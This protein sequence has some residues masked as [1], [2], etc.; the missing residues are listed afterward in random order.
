MPD[1]APSAN[2]RTPADRDEDL[3]RFRRTLEGLVGYPAT[4]GNRVDILRNGDEIF[5]SMLEAIRGAEHTVDFMTFVYWTGEIAEEFA[6][7]LAERATS[8]VRVRVLLDAVGARLMDD[9]VTTSLTD[10]GANVE[11]FRPPTTWKV[12][13]ANHRTHRKILV[14]DEAIGFTGGVGIAEEWCGDARDE[15]E[16]RDT[17]VRLEGPA[18]DGLRSAF[19]SDWGE[20]GNPVCDER[21]RFPDQPAVG[22]SI[23]QVVKGSAGSGWS[24]IGTLFE[25]MIRTAT[26]RLRLTTAYFVPDDRY[27]A[28]LID[29]IDRGVEVEVLVPGPHADK[30]FVQVAGEA[31]YEPLLDAGVRISCFQPSMLHAKVL[32]ADSMVA[33]I[34]SSNF[35]HRSLS[36]DD[37]ANVVVFDPAVAAVLDRHFDED[38]ARS[39][40]LDPSR[41]RKRSMP[42]KALEK[43][44]TVIDD[45]L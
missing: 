7:A 26:K 32:T 10:A 9:G 39:E 19:T 8:G 5:P 24:D 12:W 36:L 28:A 14:C 3:H 1:A 18:V 37:E 25:S 34:G 33:T 23:V 30:R 13:E 27:A 2:E 4:E 35:N 21:D 38:L 29:A 6:A 41:W 42:Q 15:T 44:T 31:A 43:L 17:H 22:D 11:W 40:P 20:A 45:H 16:W